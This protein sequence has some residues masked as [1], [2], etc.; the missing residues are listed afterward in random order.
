MQEKLYDVYGVVEVVE[1]LNLVH[2]FVNQHMTNIKSF[3]NTGH[4]AIKL[5]LK[6]VVVLATGAKIIEAFVA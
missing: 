2:K 6:L 1:F 3:E 4:V 5:E